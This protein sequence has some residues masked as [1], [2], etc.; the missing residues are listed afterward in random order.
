MNRYL[1]TTALDE[2]WDHD[3]PVLFLGDWCLLYEKK[4]KLK[5]LDYKVLPYHWSNTHLMKDDYKYL[6]KLYE[7]LLNE[8]TTKLNDFHQINWPKKSWRVLLGPWL[9]FATCTL[10]DRWKSISNALKN[11]NITEGTFSDENL[12]KLICFDHD[13]F[14]ELSKTDEWNHILYSSIFN[15]INKK[16]ISKSKNNKKIQTIKKIDLQSNFLKSYK[17]YDII[18]R[19]I[20]SSFIKSINGYLI[21]NNK[22]Y[23]YI[24]YIKSKIEEYKLYFLLGDF[25]LFFNNDYII[26]E[27]ISIDMFSREKL[28]YYAKHKKG[29]EKYL[30]NNIHKLMPAIYIEGFKIL[31]ENVEKNNFPKN[32]EKIYTSVG[33]WK[34]EV[35]KAWVSQNI[36][37]NIP[38]IVG[39]HGG[40]YGSAYFN[41]FEDHETKISNA[42]LSW[43]W[44]DKSNIIKSPATIMIKKSRPKWNKNGKIVII[45]AELGRYFTQMNMSHRFADRANSY[46]NRIEELINNL[47][48]EIQSN[49]VVKLSPGDK[50]RGNSMYPKLKK[51]FPQIEIIKNA[52]LDQIINNCRLSIHPCDGTTF[53]ETMGNN[54]PSILIDNDYIFPRRENTK[55]YYNKLLE[56]GISHPT[57]ESASNM[58]SNIFYDVDSWW[59]EEQMIK[60]RDSF[61]NRFIYKPKKPLHRLAEIIN[62]I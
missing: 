57:I 24:P 7:D 34:D 62:S 56:V 8:T 6:K 13:D 18:K 23:V 33:I 47:P 9:L 46:Y 50:E 36:K 1:I 2:K 14:G 40:D 60:T 22:H 26:K 31:L 19:L 30:R 3:R 39:Q 48:S 52:N 27:E 10:F 25:P 61:C 29:F 17:P 58:I 11:Y 32:I 49:I 4:N 59:N 38:L 5:N 51:R 42:Y 44:K 43:G 53:L 20:R 12:E 21:K 16:S 54:Q 15:H 55:P 41:V 37:K 45:P 28:S 35:F